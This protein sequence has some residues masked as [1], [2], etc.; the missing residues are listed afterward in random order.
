MAKKS[1]KSILEVP[2]DIAI[3]YAL[4]ATG[5]VAGLIGLIYLVLI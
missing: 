5:V 3:D 4:I 1:A 2:K